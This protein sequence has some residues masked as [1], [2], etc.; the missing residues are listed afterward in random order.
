MDCSKGPERCLTNHVQMSCGL[1]REQQQ[2]ITVQ[3]STGSEIWGK[4]IALCLKEVG[5]GQKERKNPDG[6]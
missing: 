3:F 2:N 6:R 5:F 4:C 1:V